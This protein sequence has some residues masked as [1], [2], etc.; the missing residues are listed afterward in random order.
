MEPVAENARRTGR[1]GFRAFI[2]HHDDILTH[3]VK[4]GLD[5]AGNLVA[6]VNLIIMGMKHSLSI[7]M[8][9]HAR[10]SIYH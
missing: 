4:W 2:V 6:Q 7:T 3:G 9:R 8:P 1:H 10:C 5:D